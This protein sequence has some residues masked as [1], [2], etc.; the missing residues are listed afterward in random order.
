M[1]TPV[2]AIVAGL[3]ILVYGADRFVDG[4]ASL[5]KQFGLPPLLI[6]M[7]VVGFGTSMP[8]MLVSATAALDGTYGI[9]LGNAYGSNTTNILLIIGLSAIISP[10]R[11][12]EAAIKREIPILLGVTALVI[13]LLL[14]NV[15][16]RI[17][18]VVMLVAFA[19][20]LG[21]SIYRSIRPANRV[22]A[23]EAVETA[24]EVE[25]EIRGKEY[26]TGKAAFWVLV[27][28]VLMVGSSKMLVWGAVSIAHYFGV[29]DLVVGLTVVAVG[30]SLPELAS[31]I[32]AARKG[33]DDIALGN[34]IGS[35][36]F[37]SLMVIGV[38]GLIHPLAA[39]PD[40]MRRDIPVMAATTLLLYAFCWG[41]GG[42]G[43]VT[44]LEGTILF[45][46][47]CA[48]TAYLIATAGAV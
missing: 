46:G 22:E 41:R 21:L 16:S 5:A 7:V 12:T 13:V 3:A 45:I 42:K 48:Y 8:E 4:A 29:S 25:E 24:K 11:V 47:Y 10:I 1:I 26:S 17:D 37:N 14:D 30:T 28:L 15:V 31:S 27:G 36:V 19:V 43:V 38:S 20:T 40:F 32:A 18:A 9:A 44:R 35:N 34:I 6:G 23:I 39:E 2:A 33:Q